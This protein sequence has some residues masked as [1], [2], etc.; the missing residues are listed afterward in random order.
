MLDDL[1][2]A[3][4]LGERLLVAGVERLLPPLPLAL[5]ERL[6]R[7]AVQRLNSGRPAFA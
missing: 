3:E 6:V 5:V 4:E 1:L 2:G 7:V